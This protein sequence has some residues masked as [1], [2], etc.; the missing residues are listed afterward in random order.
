[1]DP[2][3]ETR[4][5]LAAL[6]YRER[7]SGDLILESIA[8]RL[9]DEGHGLAGMVQINARRPDRCRCDMILQDLTSGRRLPISQDLGRAERGCRLDHGALEEAAA[10]ARAGLTAR[11]ELMILSKFGKR[12]SEGGGFRQAIESAVSLGVPVL[13]GISGEH[14]PAWEAFAG[15]LA[16]TLVDDADAWS[17]A[18]SALRRPWPAAA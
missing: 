16:E 11:T 1:M 12:E 10:L 5:R 18:R 9:L 7:G 2:S 6:L 8:R 3:D 17:W 13:L 14:L 4:P 15:G